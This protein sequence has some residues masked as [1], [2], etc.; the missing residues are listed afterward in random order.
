MSQQESINKPLNFQFSDIFYKHQRFSR[1]PGDSTPQLQQ[2]DSYIHF[3]FH[4]GMEH[5]RYLNPNAYTFPTSQSSFFLLLSICYLYKSV[6]ATLAGTFSIFW[7]ICAAAVLFVV[8]LVP[9]TKGQTLEEIQISIIKS[10]Q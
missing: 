7:V 1:K 2:L 6:L 8:F 9:E 3:P 10:S 4:D 5:N